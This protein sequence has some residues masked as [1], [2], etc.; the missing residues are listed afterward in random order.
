MSRTR[1][2]AVVAALALALPLVLGS[3][4]VLH[5]AIMTGFYVILA[6]SLNLI[7]GY[8]GLLS[9]ATPA[10]F[11]VGAY[12]AAILALRFGWDG[13]A[14]LGLAALAGV[15]TGIAIGFPS[16]RVSRHS[17][18]IVT[19]SA[20]LLLQLVANN[21]EDLTRGSL[22][23][24][25]IPAVRLFGVTVEARGGW[26]LLSLAVAG[27]VVLVTHLV[28]GSR[29]GRALVA[30]RENEQ[31]AL[32]VGIDVFRTR[33]FAFSLSGAFAGLAGALYAYFITYID[34][35]VFGFSVSEALL[36]MVI[37]GGSGTLSGPVAGAV[38]FTA[39]PE[40]LRIAPEVRSLLYGV[41]LLLIVLYRPAGLATWLGR[42][43][44]AAAAP[45]A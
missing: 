27:A 17:F 22:G 43:R 29:F 21:W 12:A 13:A 31:L 30:A 36:I 1:A 7:L 20:T 8:G 28:V 40:L 39:L 2:I 14:T 15:A 6:Q 11:G 42:R 26:Y 45:S 16:L 25:N 38:V 23:L 33:L 19:L 44:S 4:Y 41:I 34:P 3:P 9:L 37:L 32:A 10:F 24:A 35:G 5:I 18:V